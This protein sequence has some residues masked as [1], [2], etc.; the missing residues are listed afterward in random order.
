[1]KDLPS[2]TSDMLFDNSATNTSSPSDSTPAIDS[3][4]VSSAIQNTGSG[5]SIHSPANQPKDTLT[6]IRDTL[7]D[8]QK[9]I[10]VHIRTNPGDIDT[11]SKPKVAKATYLDLLDLEIKSTQG[12]SKSKNNKSSEIPEEA[13]PIFDPKDWKAGVSS[14]DTK[15]RKKSCRSVVFKVPKDSVYKKIQQIIKS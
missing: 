4:P 14:V 15:D 1:M 11:L 3:S 2:S 7:D 9:D 5:A 10:D 13:F 12:D 8:I 6:V